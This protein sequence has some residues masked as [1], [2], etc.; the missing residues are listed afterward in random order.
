MVEIIYIATDII[1]VLGRYKIN[2][3]ILNIFAVN[4]TAR[5]VITE[6]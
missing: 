5:I 1:N 4:S 2:E 6:N 3:S